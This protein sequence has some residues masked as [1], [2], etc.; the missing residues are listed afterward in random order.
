MKKLMAATV[1]L[2]MMTS[3]VVI[4]DEA[5]PTMPVEIVSQDAMAT[6]AESGLLVPILTMIFLVLIST[7]GN[8]YAPV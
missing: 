6:G 1:A 8:S 4:A 3:T 2:T 7:G 5:A